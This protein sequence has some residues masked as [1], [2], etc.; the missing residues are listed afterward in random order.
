MGVAVRRSDVF[1][2]AAPLIQRL[3]CFSGKRF[4]VSHLIHQRVEFESSVGFAEKRRNNLT[5]ATEF[6]P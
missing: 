3:A 5:I 2:M 1:A 6:S 4:L